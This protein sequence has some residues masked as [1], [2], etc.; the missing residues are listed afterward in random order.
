MRP[1]SR[2]S[3]HRARLRSLALGETVQTAHRHLRDA[4]RDTV[5]PLATPWQR[6]L[7][8]HVIRHLGYIHTPAHREPRLEITHIAPMSD[9]I[10]LAITGMPEDLLSHL[11][12]AFPSW[13]RDDRELDRGHP[14]LRYRPLPARNGIELY[15]LDQ[16]AS[17]I[18]RGLDIDAFEACSQQL[19]PDQLRLTRDTGHA[20]PPLIR[21][22]LT[23]GTASSISTFLRRARLLQ[24]ARPTQIDL[25]PRLGQP[26]IAVEM[27]TRDRT[28]E[29]FH[30]LLALL[31]SPHLQPR[32]H[33]VSSEGPLGYRTV[34]ARG[35][36]VIELRIQTERKS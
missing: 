29:T 17:L 27:F 13:H 36:T 23:L 20:A 1:T 14:L 30:R 16:P 24:V 21:S 4:D 34:L 32:L 7:E 11:V 18:L 2:V 31:T 9:A 25:W 28:A 15:F 10:E 8:A 19:D 26:G 12:A 35:S 22:T 5:I 3:T 6:E 33:L